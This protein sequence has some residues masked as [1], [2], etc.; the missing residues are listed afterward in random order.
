VHFARAPR[1]PCAVVCFDDEP[2]F[3]VDAPSDARSKLTA[4]A[5]AEERIPLRKPAAK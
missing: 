5:L 4:N 3:V 1:G 2:T